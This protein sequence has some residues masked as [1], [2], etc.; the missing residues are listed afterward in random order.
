[1]RVARAR[2]DGAPVHP[3]RDDEFVLLL[4]RRAEEMADESALQPVL[5]HVGRAVRKGA[6]EDA[7]L[8]RVFVP[9]LRAA[10]VR[11]DRTGARRGI[12]A[13]VEVVER[14]LGI[15]MIG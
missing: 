1:E 14:D 11:G 10:D 6:A 13:V 9:A 2:V 5:R 8:L 15:G 12:A 4:E 7:V 3:L